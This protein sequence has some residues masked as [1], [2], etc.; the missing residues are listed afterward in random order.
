MS[1][2]VFLVI[3]LVYFPYKGKDFIGLSFAKALVG[4]TWFFIWS[5]VVLWLSKS[6][7]SVELS[8]RTIA[9]FTVII[10]IWFSSPQIVRAIGKKPKEYIEKNPKRFLVRFELPVMLLKFFEILFQQS[11][12][13]YILFVILN[14]VPLQEKILWFTFIVAIIH[15]GNI[16]VMSWRWTVFYLILSIP[17]AMVFGTLI[18]QGYALVTMSVHL[19]FYLLFNG[20][21]WISRK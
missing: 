2:I 3:L 4:S 9:L 17:M 21:Y 16:F 15:A 5:L 11:V 14:V 6:N 19:V 7:V 12:F 10:C 8:Y 18:F 13:I 1:V 20:R